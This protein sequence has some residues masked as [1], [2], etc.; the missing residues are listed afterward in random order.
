MLALTRP[1]FF[2][3]VHGEFKQLKKH[4]SL[5]L[6]MGMDNDHVLIGENGRVFELDGVSVKHEEMVPSG[7]VLVDGLGVGDVGSIV[8]RDRKHLGQDGLIVVVVTTEQATGRIVAGPD[9]ISRGFVYV[10]EAEDMLTEAR[11]I[12]RRTLDECRRKNVHEWGNI[13]SQVRDS[14]SSYF[15]SRTKR[16]PMILP[17]IQEI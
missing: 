6:A 17:V 16:S 13:K 15:Y 11:E 10:R 1:K 4:A 12:A 2:F 3:P 5:A 9:I 14:L 8:L 7:R